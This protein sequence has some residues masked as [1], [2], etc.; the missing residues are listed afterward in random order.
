MVLVV[1]IGNTQ[2]VIGL[3]RREYSEK[4]TAIWRIK[5]DKTDAT[6]DIRSKLYALMHESHIDRSSIQSI[7]IASVVPALLSVWRHLI[8][9]VFGLDVLECTA[10]L[11]TD[12]GLFKADYTNPQEIGADRVADAVAVNHIFGGPAIVVDFGTATN[13]EVI[14]GSG[15]FIG[16]VIAPGIMTGA[17]AMFANATRLAA[18]DLVVPPNVIGRSTEEA[19]QSGI[20]LG[21][22][23]RVDGIVGMICDQIC[24]GRENCQH[25]CH[26]VATGGLAYLVAEQSKMITDVR[27]DLTLVGLRLLAHAYDENLS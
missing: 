14:D 22:A 27:S 3:Y 21:E 23:A 19:V 24:G 7:V 9:T 11:A 16:G 13:F 25:S 8:N 15:T 26:I 20:I 6:G 10:K 1:D 4:A 5:T 2:T 17:N 18:T 12:L